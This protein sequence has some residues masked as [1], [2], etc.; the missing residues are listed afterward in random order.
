MHTVEITYAD[1]LPEIE[2]GRGDCHDF[3][4]VIPLELTK[5]K[6]EIFHSAL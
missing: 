3:D 1:I 5:R 6:V 2:F 4:R